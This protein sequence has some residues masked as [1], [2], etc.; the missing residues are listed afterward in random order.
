MVAY[1]PITLFTE[2]N[3]INS[4]LVLRP[5]STF[6][7]TS[8]FMLELSNMAFYSYGRPMCS[9]YFITSRMANETPFEIV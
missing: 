7:N 3:D 9:R 5:L 6:A 1:S 4:D 8:S 2:F